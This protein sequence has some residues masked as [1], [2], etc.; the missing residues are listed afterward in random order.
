M[1][2][3]LTY[4]FLQNVPRIEEFVVVHGL[5]EGLC[6]FFVDELFYISFMRKC[7]PNDGNFTSNYQ[8]H[9][10]C[11]LTMRKF[12]WCAK[13]ETYICYLLTKYNM[14]VFSLIAPQHPKNAIR[15]TTHPTIIK[16]IVG[17]VKLPSVNN[18]VYHMQVSLK[19]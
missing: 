15:N 9:N 19:D 6:K 17:A 2:I 12:S 5:F 16:R 13:N 8:K 14:H 3:V 7:G 10:N 1:D 11:K 18:L 4:F